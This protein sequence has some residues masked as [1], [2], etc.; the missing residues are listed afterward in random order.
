MKGVF[1][2]T[3]C[4]SNGIG[5]VKKIYALKSSSNEIQDRLRGISQDKNQKQP[6]TEQ[7]FVYQAARELTSNSDEIFY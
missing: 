2:F 7:Q 1:P 6:A 4:E 3:L 5:V